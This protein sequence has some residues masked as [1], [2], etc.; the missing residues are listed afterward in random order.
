[1]LLTS[2]LGSAGTGDTEED[3]AV[4]EEAAAD[5]QW[6]LVQH[7]HLLQQRE[8]LTSWLHLC[9]GCA[10]VPAW[11]TRLRCD[12][13]V[14]C[15]CWHDGAVPSQPCR[16]SSCMLHTAPEWPQHLP[17]HASKSRDQA[18]HDCSRL[19]VIHGWAYAAPCCQTAITGSRISCCPASAGQPRKR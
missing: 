15:S 11:T 18:C 3:A 17:R 4:K 8:R 14:C 16:G 9:A 12:C 1:M 6:W 19:A 7:V 10:A 13:S 2:L 5:R